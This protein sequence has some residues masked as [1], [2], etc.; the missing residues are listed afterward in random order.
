MDYKIGL[1]LGGGG[2]RGSFQ[3]GVFKVLLELDIMKNVKFVSG[4]SIGSINALMVMNH[5]SF[6]EMIE[7]WKK[8]DN[9]G[10]YG[11]GPDRFKM[12]KKGIFSIKDLYKIIKEDFS[13]K[14][15][16]NSEVK[17]FATAVKIP[18]ASMADQMNLLK[19]EK[20]VFHLNDMD[21]PTKG[22]LAS[23]SMPVLFGSSDVKDEH[24]IDGGVKDNLPIQPLI[25]EGCEIIISVPLQGSLHPKKYRNNDV[26][27]VNIEPHLLF[28]PLLIDV[29]NF[30]PK[31][32]E[33]RIEYGDM[34]ANFIFDKLHD[35]KIFDRNT[36]KWMKPEGFKYIRISRDE[37]F[38]LKFLTKG[39]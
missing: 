10:I 13:I 29:I 11:D 26:L 4:T 1:A 20:T 21:D 5:K 38:K 35:Q 22:A 24:Y 33:H 18:H 12:D 15:I 32:I 23:A 9:S 30:D 7:V 31:L 25:E 28:N 36:K 14:D 8:F 37:E 3:I 16:K 39:N 34:L 27:L 6:D 17:G 2:A 19:M